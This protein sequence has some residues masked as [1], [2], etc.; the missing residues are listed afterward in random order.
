MQDQTVISVRFS[1]QGKDRFELEAAARERLREFGIPI[2][3]VVGDNTY[4]K[5]FMDVDPLVEGVQEGRVFAW[6]AEVEWRS[7]DG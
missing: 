6:R 3:K 2:S 5:L 7:D 4:G 1:V